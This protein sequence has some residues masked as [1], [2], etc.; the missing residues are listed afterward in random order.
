MSDSLF[1]ALSIPLASQIACVER[2]IGMRARVYPRWVA[3]H[4]LTQAKA[5]HEI[6]AM[7]AVLRTLEAIRDTAREDAAR[8]GNRV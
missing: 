1:G 6:A 5:D 7:Q 4:K 8:M 2:E 3:D